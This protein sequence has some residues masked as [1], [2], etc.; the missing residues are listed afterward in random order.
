MLV[1]I[2]NLNWF[3]YFSD[4]SYSED[5]YRSRIFGIVCYFLCLDF[6]YLSDNFIIWLDFVNMY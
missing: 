3:Y 6:K 5:M 4:F 2:L 1:A